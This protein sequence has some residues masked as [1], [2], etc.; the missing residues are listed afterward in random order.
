MAGSAESHS[1]TPDVALG[2]LQDALVS[3]QEVGQ[4]ILANTIAAPGG[5]PM[6]V[7]LLPGVVLREDEGGTVTLAFVT[8]ASTPAEAVP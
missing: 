7:L 8:P 4:E 2:L 3:L 6:L 5:E 1:L